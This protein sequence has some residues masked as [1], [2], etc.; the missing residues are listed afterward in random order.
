MIVTFR[1][2]AHAD[3]IMFGDIAVNLLKLMGHS[4][5]VPGALLAEDV[6]AALDRLR[7][8]VAANKAAV[9]EHSRRRLGRAHGKFSASRLTFDRVAC[10]CRNGAMR[11][12]V[13][14]VA[15]SYLK[16]AP[17]SLCVLPYRTRRVLGLFL[18]ASVEN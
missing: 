9:A 10:G 16:L 6:P 18:L 3:I 7:K 15:M 5:T 17:A 1:S 12:D 11:R 4:G 2:K 14:Q 8:A 13:G